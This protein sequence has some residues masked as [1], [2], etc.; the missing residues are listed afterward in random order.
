M[1]FVYDELTNFLKKNTYEC[2][3]GEKELK[4]SVVLEGFLS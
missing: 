2:Q 4:D 3:N 1:D